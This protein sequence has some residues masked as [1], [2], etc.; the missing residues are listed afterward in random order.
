MIYEENE[1][2]LVMEAEAVQV[3]SEWQLETEVDGYT[4]IGYIR[5]NANTVQTGPPRGFLQYTFN[6][7]TPGK[8]QLYLRSNKNNEEPTWS[9]DCY[10]RMEGQ[11]GTLDGQDSF[12]ELESYTK[13]YQK[14]TP[15]IWRYYTRLELKD[16]TKPLPIFDLAQGVYTLHVA[17]RS[18]NF[19]IDR[20]V[21]RNIDTQTETTATTTALPESPTI[22]NTGDPT[23]GGDGGDDGE[24]T[25]D[26]TDGED[27]VD[28]EPTDPGDTET[29]IETDLEGEVDVLIDAGSN[30]EPELSIL[31]GSVWDSVFAPDIDVS[32]IP[33][34]LQSQAEK[35]KSHRSGKSFQYYISSSTIRPGQTADVTIGFAENWPVAC[36]IANPNKRVFNVYVNGQVFVENLSVFARVGCYTALTITKQFMADESGVFLIDFQPVKQNPMVSLI[37]VST[38]QESP[39][40]GGDEMPDNGPD[41]DYITGFFLVDASDRSV[42]ME[43]TPESEIDLAGLPETLSITVNTS[44][45]VAGVV[46]EWEGSNR[47]RDGNPPFSMNGKSGPDK[48]VPVPYLTVP[49]AKVVTA[50]PRGPLDLRFDQKT[51]INFT[52][53]DSSIVADSGPKSTLID[54]GSASEDTRTVSGNVWVSHGDESI[55]G[56]PVE[57]DESLFQTHR[58]GHPSFNYTVDGFAS[59]EQVDVTLGFAEIYQPFCVV[60][61]RIFN[62]EV[63]AEEFFYGLDV[64]S[65]ARGCNAAFIVTRQ[66]LANTEGQVVIEFSQVTKN[67][68][69]SLVA[70]RASDDGSIGADA[71]S[72][73]PSTEDGAV[74]EQASAASTRVVI[75][76]GSETE[77]KAL[78]GGKSWRSHFST[79]IDRVPDAYS[80]DTFKSHRSGQAPFNYTIGGFNAYEPAGVTLGFAENYSPLCKTGRRVFNVILNGDT[81]ANNVDVFA[82]VDCFTTY[83]ITKTSNANE[84]GEFV[85]EFEAV[86]QNPM[87]SLIVIQPIAADTTEEN[88]ELPAVGDASATVYLARPSDRANI[89]SLQNGDTVDM[90]TVGSSLTIVVEPT[91]AVEAV[92][93]WYQGTFQREGISPYSMGGKRGSSGYNELTYLSQP[94]TKTFEFAFVKNGAETGKQIFSFTMLDGMSGTD[95]EPDNEGQETV[96][97]STFLINAGGADDDDSFFRGTPYG[98]FRKSSFDQ[99]ISNVPD[100]FLQEIFKTHRS[101]NETFDYVVGGYVPGEMLELTLGFAENYA[102]NCRETKR[103][104]DVEVNGLPFGYDFDVYGAVG[105]DAALVERG[106]YSANI[107]GELVIRFIPLKGD[108]MVSLIAINSIVGA[109]DEPV[110]DKERSISGLVLASSLD[111]SVIISSILDGGSIDLD[112]TGLDITIVAM[113]TDEVERVKFIYNGDAQDEGSAPYAMNGKRGGAAFQNVNYLAYPGLKTVTIQAYAS[114]KKT[115]IDTMTISFTVTGEVEADEIFE[116]AYEPSVIIDAGGDSE[117]DVTRAMVSPVGTMSYAFDPLISNVPAEFDQAT[118]QTHKSAVAFSYT[119]SGFYPGETA[120]VTLG[121]A[122]NYSPNCFTGKRKFGA[123]VNGIVFQDSI[124]V[125]GTVGCNAAYV[126][127][128]QFTANDSGSFVIDFVSEKRNPMVSLIVVDL[129][130]TTDSPSTSPSSAPSM[131]PSDAPS[132]SPSSSPSA[133]PS[134]IP[135]EPPSVSTSPSSFPSDSPSDT[136]SSAPSSSPTIT[137]QIIESTV[138]PSTLPSASP[139][140]I[141]SS[142]PSSDPVPATTPTAAITGVWLINA[143]SGSK[144]AQLETGT[145]YDISVV[146]DDLSIL[147]ETS[148]TMTH[149]RFNWMGATQVEGREPYVMAGKDAMNNRYYSVPYLSRIG[150]KIVE[151]DLFNGSERI[152]MREL[153]FGVIDSD[154]DL[155]SKDFIFADS[156]STP[157]V[158][159]NAGA[160]NEDVSLIGGTIWNTYNNEGNISSVPAPFTEE[161]FMSHR[162]GYAFN[163]TIGGF[164]PNEAAAVTLGFAENYAPNCHPTKRMFDVEVN[165]EEFQY[166]LDVYGEA[167]CFGAYVKTLNFRADTQGEFVIDFRSVKRNPMVSVIIIDVIASEPSDWP[168]SLP[169]D[170]PSA[171]PSASPSSATETSS[172]SIL[173]YAL[174]QASNRAVLM[175]LEDGSIYSL[176]TVGDSLSLTVDTTGDVEYVK[177]TWDSS[178]HDE[179]NTPYSMNGKDT[180]AR[181]NPVDY[182][183]SI[184]VKT[185]VIETFD[186]NNVKLDAVTLTIEAVA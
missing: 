37:A 28:P 54:A 178:K 15:G 17:G 62:V 142:A 25:P 10:I 106:S 129:P 87:V 109:S 133:V 57:Y 36:D 122:E 147:V 5:F 81:F 167:G 64:F 51:A 1:G 45:I 89:Q 38:D 16:K 113:T 177:F 173:S 24:E 116:D 107:E 83:F 33:T 138:A 155:L 100:A 149:V 124:D 157:R 95:E 48:F 99:P 130:R 6:I 12:G 181:F 91:S 150:E 46:F 170:M 141:P 159:I 186:S 49:G 162:S 29:P 135:S 31:Q 184:G 50:E 32:G 79:P 22:F 115:L 84:N 66:F 136:P 134:S 73:T 128:K 35:F 108:A 143:A 175:P 168:S 145:E 39:D 70:V 125:F 94:G 68:M 156:A 55:T 2:L 4:G 119:V 3:P 146:G 114:D 77:N 182:L 13:L 27:T 69:V 65:E 80:E 148:G 183:A 21:F 19:F 139:T 126:V 7:N 161:I 58:S 26:P 60:G 179:G 61:G 88:D 75:D 76:A 176:A 43:I 93:F 78:V 174:V 59:G 118:F 121:F 120:V 96:T 140:S 172:S 131:I 47:H 103:T 112:E 110:D 158:V 82:A 52:I 102:P 74:T 169:S 18:M 23:D 185:I 180:G 34:V 41:V 92:K 14:G 8:Y 53:V 132:S 42:L 152:E 90:A 30:N 105:C 97:R 71:V 11:G 137:E 101:G 165:G 166:N 56:V 111:R 104:F 67:P 171:M 20:I 63:N 164:Y 85:L 117:V 72:Q 160:E 151:I 123:S 163:Y 153:S 9:N 144:L 127:T 98:R 44:S 86:K 40:E 154:F